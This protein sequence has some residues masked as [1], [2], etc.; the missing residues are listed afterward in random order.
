MSFASSRRLVLASAAAVLLAACGGGSDTPSDPQGWA[1]VTALAT[2]DTSVG[3]GATPATGSRVA[4][5]YTGYLYDQRVADRKGT[6]FDSNVGAAPFAFTLGSGQVIAG[7]D[8]GVRGMRVG[9]KR[10]VTIPASLGYGASGAGTAIPPN[11]ALV[12]DI[13]LVAVN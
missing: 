12:F 2:T 1:G 5:T 6:R 8:Q 10:T 4:V 3:T 7:F 9:G 11:A 13:E